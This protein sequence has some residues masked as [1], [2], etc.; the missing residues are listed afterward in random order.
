M[1]SLFKRL[2]GGYLA[3]LCCAPW[4][5]AEPLKVPLVTYYD[6]A[7]F[8]VGDGRQ[9][10]NRELAAL[11]TAQSRGR[12][13]FVPT[14]YPKGRLDAMLTEPSFAAAVAWLHP[15]FVRDEARTKFAWTK[16]L[17]N[18]VDLVVSPMAVPLEFSGVASLHGKTLG[19]IVNQRYADI[20]PSIASGALRREDAATQEGN[21]RKLMLRRVDVVF[22]SRSTL[23]WFRNSVDGFTTG[24][25]IAAQPRNRFS[26]HVMLT[27]ALPPELI[28]Y[29]QHT[30]AEL[31]GNA[32]WRAAMERY[33]AA[34]QMP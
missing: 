9:G 3:V 18:E 21:L 7:P 28:D 1:L 30:I 14:Y 24:L 2:L 6:Y 26:R 20:E 16:P 15:A 34:E 19:T 13:V 31:D 5:T 10:L 29:V 33:H 32:R 25:H 12:Y 11:L 22:V 4:A 17:M 23:W 27:R 8:Q